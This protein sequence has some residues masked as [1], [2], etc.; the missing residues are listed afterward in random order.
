MLAVFDLFTI[1]R[2]ATALPLENIEKALMLTRD[3]RINK[4]ITI[5][6]FKYSFV[7]SNSIILEFSR[8]KSTVSQFFVL[9]SMTVQMLFTLRVCTLSMCHIYRMQKFVWS[10]V[11]E[12]RPS[13]HM[14]VEC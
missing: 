8:G 1:K 3:G 14:S 10:S 9:N 13:K 4:P 2:L 5:I 11:V 7:L 6:E 12:S